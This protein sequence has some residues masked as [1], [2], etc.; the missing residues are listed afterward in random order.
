MASRSLFQLLC[1][2][3]CTCSP[4]KIH[5]FALVS[6]ADERITE[7]Y[8]ALLFRRLEAHGVENE[9]GVPLYEG[10]RPSGVLKSFIKQSLTND[11]DPSMVCTTSNILGFNNY[12]TS[13]PF[14]DTHAFYSFAILIVLSTD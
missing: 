8:Y 14:A 9:T 2:W 12:A 7:Q 5:S 6:I 13:C 11:R 3:C 4:A 10:D 1:A